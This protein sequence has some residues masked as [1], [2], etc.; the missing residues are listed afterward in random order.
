[1]A[2]H[3]IT[4]K[5][6]EALN[7]ALMDC[8]NRIAELG[9]RIGIDPSYLSKY[10]SGA[11]KSVQHEQWCLLCAYIPEI[12]DRPVTCGDVNGNGNAIG[13]SNIVFNGKCADAIELFRRA[14][15]DAVMAD[16]NIIL[17]SKVQVYN[18]LK[19]LQIK[20]K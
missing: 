11:V 20:G 2:T 15:M 19:D 14:A 1:M 18:I 17:E 12:D 9:R 8:D 10:L 7:M 6:R 5:V 16:E 4:D 3:R 13:N